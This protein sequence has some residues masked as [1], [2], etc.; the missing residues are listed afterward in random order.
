[1]NF[2]NK[3]RN[4]RKMEK[5]IYFFS[6]LKIFTNPANEFLYINVEAIGKLKKSIHFSDEFLFNK[7][8]NNRKMK[9]LYIFF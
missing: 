8:R 4:G 7:C 3:C 6:N 1:M 5:Y 9:K 2:C